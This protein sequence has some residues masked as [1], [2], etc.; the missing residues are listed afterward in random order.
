M[1]KTLRKTYIFLLIATIFTACTEYGDF[2]RRLA[3]ADSLMTHEMPDS[4][5]RMLCGMNEEA[6]HMPDAQRMRHLLLRSNAQNKAYVDFTSDSIGCLLV[7][8]YDAHGTPNERMLAH[9]IKGCAYRDMGDQPASLRCYNDAVAAADTSR[10][11]C[12]YDQLSIIYGQI[13]DIF[14][15]RA[16]PDNALQAY[17]YAERYAWKAKDTINVFTIW[18]NKSDAL[19][20]KGE[21]QEALRI[22]EA[23][24]EGFRAM[25]YPQKAARVLGLCIKWYALQGEFDKAKVAMDEYENHSGY[26][27]EGGD[28]KPGKEGYYHIKGTYFLEKG[29]LDSAEH[30]FR[31][32]QHSG[33]TR[34]DQYLATWGLTQLYYGKMPLDSIGKYALQTFLHSDTL[35]NIGAAENLQKAQAQYNYTRHLE[36]AHRK[37]LEAKDMEISRRNWIIAGV[38]LLSIIVLFWRRQIR[39]KKSELRTANRKN[40]Q[41]STQLHTANE[42]NVQLNTQLD[43]NNLKIA[44]LNEQISEKGQ[45]IKQLNEVINK[46]AADLQLNAQLQQTVAILEERLATYLKEKEIHSRTH[47]LN[48]LQQQPVVKHFTELANG[49]VA[50]PTYKDW[51]TLYPLVEEFYPQLAVLRKDISDAEYQICVLTKLGFRLSDI[52]HLTHLDNNNLCVMRTRLLTKLFHT[53]GGTSMFDKRIKEL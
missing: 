28:A 42:E 15:R 9:Y 29:E 36:T 39:L 48:T 43:A 34:N 6:E 14:D 19:I 16:M 3:V 31:K 46:N 47:N 21:I 41:L 27:L 53:K 35:Y 30:Y 12:N 24:A 8:Y 10:T 25:G 50:Y 11:D 4:A 23:A 1:M 33:T 7:D 2:E 20:D 26:F 37:E 40:T 17:E 18:G 22:K 38:L 49:R 44:Q 45:L 13:A 51:H 52:G 5:Y 32:L